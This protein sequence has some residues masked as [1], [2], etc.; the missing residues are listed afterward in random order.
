LLHFFPLPL[1]Y[2]GSLK[3]NIQEKIQMNKKT[4]VLVLMSLFALNACNEEKPK[5]TPNNENNASTHPN[6]ISN[7]SS[8]NNGSHNN[9]NNGNDNGRTTHTPNPQP[10]PSPEL[11][12]TP[13]SRS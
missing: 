4:I 7:R 3:T 10:A 6:L 11:N 9:Q 13:N 5:T 8:Q 2:F 12:P 1:P